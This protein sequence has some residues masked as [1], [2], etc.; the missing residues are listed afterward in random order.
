[1]ALGNEIARLARSITELADAIAANRGPRQHLSDKDRQAARAEI[2]RS[3]QRLDE[4]RSKL[5]DER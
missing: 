2:E 4:L 1:M 5:A 3:V